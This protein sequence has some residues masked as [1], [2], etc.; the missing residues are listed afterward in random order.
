[1]VETGY[2]ERELG[3]RG[4]RRSGGGKESEVIEFPFQCSVK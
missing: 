1:M 4:R 3:R 2:R